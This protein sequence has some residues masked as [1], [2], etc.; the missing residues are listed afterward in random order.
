VRIYILGQFLS[1]WYQVLHRNKRGDG[2]YQI[3]S[4]SALMTADR[5]VPWAFSS[6]MARASGLRLMG[7]VNWQLRMNC[8]FQQSFGLF[9]AI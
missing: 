7:E 4:R 9:F 5:V 6:R 3:F 1:F 2:G 8:G